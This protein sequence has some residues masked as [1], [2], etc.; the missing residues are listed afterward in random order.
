M[1]AEL[2]LNS[3]LSKKMMVQSRSETNIVG[4]SQFIALFTHQLR[5]LLIN[6]CIK[7]KYK[8]QFE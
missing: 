5:I 8:Q 7:H 4:T 3:N 6:S 2:A 1:I